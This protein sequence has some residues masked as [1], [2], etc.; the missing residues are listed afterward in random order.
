MKGMCFFMDF[1]TLHHTESWKRNTGLLRAIQQIV[2][3]CIPKAPDEERR[4]RSRRAL[5]LFAK[6]ETPGQLLTNKPTNSTNMKLEES[7]QTVLDKAA[8]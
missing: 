4:Y 2:S 8:F 3:I 1:S 7:G 5:H 6:M